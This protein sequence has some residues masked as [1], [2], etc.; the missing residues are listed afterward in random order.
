MNFLSGAGNVAS[1]VNTIYTDQSGFGKSQISSRDES[2]GGTGSRNG[3]GEAVSPV[4]PARVAADFLAREL[5]QVKNSIPN[6]LGVRA[7][8]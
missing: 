6:T 3:E 2:S 4:F 5:H 8:G 7:H 1:T